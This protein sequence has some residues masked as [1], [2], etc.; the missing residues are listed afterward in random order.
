MMLAEGMENRWAASDGALS[1]PY[2]DGQASVTVTCGDAEA[3]A[4]IEHGAATLTAAQARS[5]M[6]SVGVRVLDWG[7]VPVTV[8]HVGARYCTRADVEAYGDLNGDGFRD[9]AR[10]PDAAVDA[11]IRAAEEAI[12]AGTRRSF[13]ERA[14][15]VRLQGGGALEELPV[16]DA[17]SIGGG[18]SLLHGRQARSDA[19]QEVEVV[20]GAPLDAAVRRACTQ[21]AASYLRPRAYAENARGTSMDGLYVSLSLATGE[22]GSETG[23]P[24]VD[25]VIESH[26]SRRAVVL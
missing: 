15:T 7:G 18:A 1:L 9:A 2:A 10:Y 14:V 16:E 5:L 24:Y 12:E 19:A 20:Y 8:E 4:A 6:P 21:L 17:K 3:E 13:C 11:A 26:R 23:L 25:S 22:E